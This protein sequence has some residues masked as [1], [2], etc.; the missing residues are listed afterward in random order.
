MDRTQIPRTSA[1]ALPGPNA[2]LREAR[3][4]TA[5]LR[6]QLLTGDAEAAQVAR[7]TFH[8]VHWEHGGQ[9]IFPLTD[10]QKNPRRRGDR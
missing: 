6:A 9:Q 7:G 5:G 8:L 2:W 1:R 3:D 4:R 10:D